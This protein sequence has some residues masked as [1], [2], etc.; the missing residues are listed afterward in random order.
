MRVTIRRNDGT[1][2]DFDLA[3]FVRTR[4]FHEIHSPVGLGLA[5]GVQD[6]ANTVANLIVRLGERGVLSCEEIVDLLGGVPIDDLEGTVVHARAPGELSFLDETIADLCERGDL[7]LST[8]V[9][10]LLLHERI[11]ILRDL[12]RTQRHW[13]SKRDGVGRATILEIE[14]GLLTL[15]LRLDLSTADVAA[16]DT[17]VDCLELSVRTANV[18]AALECRHV[19]DILRRRIGDIPRSPGSQRVV[20]EIQAVLG[21]L[22]IPKGWWRR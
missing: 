5:E 1:D 8:R 6:L 19:C 12:V 22:G 11:H 18:L 17:P 2:R 13:L 14:M 15:G 21:R 4:I 16:L 9:R 3:D 7:Q 10:N 20:R